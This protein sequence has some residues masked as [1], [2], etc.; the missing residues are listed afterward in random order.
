MDY[1]I[2]LSAEAPDRYRE[3]ADEFRIAMA[4][5]SSAAAVMSMRDRAAPGAVLMLMLLPNGEQN[6]AGSRHGI[7]VGYLR[8]SAITHGEAYGRFYV[9]IEIVAMPE[10][11]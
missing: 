1:T 2:A 6:E 9:T 4:D 7:A 10:T 11:A 8:D 5:P 3:A